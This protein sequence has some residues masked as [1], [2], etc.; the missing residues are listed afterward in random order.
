MGTFSYYVPLADGAYAVT[1]GFL[2]ARQQDRCRNRIFYVVA[3]GTVQVANLDVLGPPDAS[4]GRH[5]VSVSVSLLN[6]S[7]AS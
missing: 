5:E 6:S 7:P 2:E 1:L 4:H 3:N